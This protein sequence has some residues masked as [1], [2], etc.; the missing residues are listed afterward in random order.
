MTFSESLPFRIKAFL[1]HLAGSATVFAIYLYL[2]FTYWYPE[3]YFTIENAVQVTILIGVSLLLGPL[4]TFLIYVPGKK[5]LKFDIVVIVV[6][7]LIFL[8][9][10]VWVTYKEH[11]VFSVFMIDEFRVKRAGNVDMSAINP[12]VFRGQPEHGLRLIYTLPPQNPDDR[13]RLVK[14]LFYGRGDIDVLPERYR[15]IKDH[16][17]EVRKQSRDV[18]KI[19]ENHPQIKADYLS[20]M[21]KLGGRVEDYLFLPVEARKKSFTLVL[22]KT[23][24]SYAG[25]LAV[26]SWDAK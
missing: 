9:W 15:A 24:A 17:D 16:L 8:S 13:S 6:V 3:P 25:F 12:D 7:Q 5:G 18:N 21:K 1:T 14:E 10:G 26:D 11:P 23:D 22:H 19:L 20:L 2:V 4:L